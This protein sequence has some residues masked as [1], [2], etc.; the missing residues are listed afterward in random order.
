MNIKTLF[1]LAAALAVSFSARAADLSQQLGIQT[2]TLRNMKFEQVVEF[3]TKHGI[4][5]L[6]MI[7]NHMDPK[8]PLEETKRKKA[9]LDAAGLTVYTF[10]VAG[11]SLDKED[12][13][14]LFEFAKFMGI[15]VIVVEP[16]DYK[17]FDN[18][19]ELVK[20]YDIKIAVHNHGI[21]SLYGNPAVVRALLKHRDPRIGVCMDA[22]WITSTGMDPTKVFKEYEGRVYDIHLK[23]KKVEKTQGDD[24]SFDTH[25][26]KGLGKLENL[27]AE[28]KKVNWPGVLA[29]ETDSNDFARDPNEFVAGAKAFVEQNGK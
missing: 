5:N 23:D 1:S 13:R 16:S 17:I 19:E 26:G 18:L 6:Q 22:G 29:I 8:A 7:G 28:L 14:K 21:R 10:G 27:L 20:E 11:T 15:K 4:K 25:I 24:V 3:A 2:W 12:N 9:V